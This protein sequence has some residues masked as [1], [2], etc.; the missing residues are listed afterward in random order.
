MGVS[1]IQLKNFLKNSNNH[2]IVSLRKSECIR[3]IL[4]RANKF[5]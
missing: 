1:G 3:N 4:M 2:N 5:Y